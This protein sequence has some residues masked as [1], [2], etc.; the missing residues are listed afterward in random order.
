MKAVAILL[1]IVAAACAALTVVYYLQ[2]EDA[3]RFVENEYNKAQ[4]VCRQA[5]AATGTPEGDALAN[6][7][8]KAS[9][10]LAYRSN[11]ISQPRSY[12]RMNAVAS[13]VSLCLGVGLLILRRRK[14]TGA[15]QTSA[16]D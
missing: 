6:E 12:S 16:A 5:S 13:A 7:C 9:K 1:L 3:Q 14:N 4:K 10:T 2:Y 15:P 8:S 11:M